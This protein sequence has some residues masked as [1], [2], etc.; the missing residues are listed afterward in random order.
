[1]DKDL[2][3]QGLGRRLMDFAEAD[4]AARGGRLSVVETSSRPAYEPTR[5][6]Y[7]RLGYSQAACIADFYGPGDD[8]VVFTKSLS[9]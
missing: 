7:E 9:R 1:M 4:I 2:H 5:A 6:F 3:G 8:K